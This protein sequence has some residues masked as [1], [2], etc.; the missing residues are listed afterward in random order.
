M[1]LP[2]RNAYNFG[3]FSFLHYISFLC[4]CLLPL[5]SPPFAHL[6]SSLFSS[7]SS[8]MET[9]LSIC[10]SIS[11]PNPKSTCSFNPTS[12][13]LR[14]H[15]KDRRFLYLKYKANGYSHLSVSSSFPIRYSKGEVDESQSL[16]LDNIRHSLI[17]QEDSIIFS[18]LLRAQYDY[19]A[20]TY[21]PDAFS[22]KGFQ[23]SMVEY[24]VRET[25]KVHAQMGRY[26]SPDEH[27][28]FPEDLPKS[29]FPCLQYPQILHPCAGSININKKVWAVYFRD[30]LPRLVKAGDDGNCG[31]AAVCDTMCLQAMSR[32]IHY[33]KFVAEAKFL[34][35]PAEYEAAI[36]QQA[37]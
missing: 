16:T 34:Q 19:N 22:M 13:L 31:S 10:A 2:S 36:R 17:E 14:N 12:H 23:G 27:P 24:I 7:H 26:R 33:G 11:S 25:E 20:D 29:T 4:F 9:M 35:S 1:K 18:L 32:R 5:L 37:R 30:L 8:S 28:Y 15:Q 21:D 6:L 3:C